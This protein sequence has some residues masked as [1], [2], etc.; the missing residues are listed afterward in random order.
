M[1]FSFNAIK[2]IGYDNKEKRLTILLNRILI[3][4]RLSTF[5]YV[6]VSLFPLHTF[7][8]VAFH[9]AVCFFV[10]TTRSCFDGSEVVMPEKAFT[11]MA[12]LPV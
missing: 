11:A 1:S 10:S 12:F 2:I 4:Q 6:V 3:V 8:C 7:Q 9:Q 5:F